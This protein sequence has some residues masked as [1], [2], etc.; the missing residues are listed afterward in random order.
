MSRASKHVRL[1]D[2]ENGEAACGVEN[3]EPTDCLV[4]VGVSSGN[5]GSSEDRLNIRQ[6]RQ[7]VP[8]HSLPPHPFPVLIIP[9]GIE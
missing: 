5:T 6:N 9:L 1:L 7:E 3:E 8:N 4:P 2:S